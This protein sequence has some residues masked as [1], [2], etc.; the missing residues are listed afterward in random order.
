ML[1]RHSKW[2]LN[3]LNKNV[4]RALTP[5]ICFTFAS[6]IIMKIVDMEKH[7]V[8]KCGVQWPFSA[9]PNAKHM[10]NQL[11]RN[12]ALVS[13]IQPNSGGITDQF[14]AICIRDNYYTMSL[15]QMKAVWR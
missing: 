1:R 15:R 2:G 10:I 13:W 3:E 8:V 6:I 5:D 9:A 11:E 14:P 12:E 7:H 4:S